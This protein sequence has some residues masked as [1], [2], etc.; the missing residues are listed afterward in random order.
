M[1]IAHGDRRTMTSEQDRGPWSQRLTA[2][3]TAERTLG[4]HLGRLSG[5][6]PLVGFL[7]GWAILLEVSP[8]GTVLGGGGG[9][10]SVKFLW[11]ESATGTVSGWLGCLPGRCGI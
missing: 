1:Q 4:G 7:T 9:G 10:V 2:P 3:C 5:K 8:M 11:L 6:M